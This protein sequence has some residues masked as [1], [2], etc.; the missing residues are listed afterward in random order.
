MMR[1]L[2]SGVSGLKT[3]QQKMDVI[4]NNIANVNTTAFKS[5]ST[6]FQ[7]VMYQT[8]SNASGG[9][10]T[11]GGVN[12]RQIG[13]G[14]TTAANKVS[15]TTQGSSEATGD[16]L[17]LRLVDKQSTNFFIVSDGASN[18]FTRSG[19]FYVDGNGNLAMTST[20]Y[21]VQGWQVDPTTKA[22]KRDTVSPLKVMSA[23]NKTSDP[24]NT[25]KAHI[26]G[27]IDDQ[28]PNVN[29]TSGHVMNLTFYDNLGYSYTARFAVNKGAADTSNPPQTNNYTVALESITSDSQTDSEGNPIDI[30]AN[31]VNEAT[32]ADGQRARLDTIFGSQ[33]GRKTDSFKLDAESYTMSADGQTIRTGS[34][35]NLYTVSLSQITAEAKKGPNATVTFNPTVTGAPAKTVKISDIF[36]G[37]SSAANNYYNSATGAGATATP[38]TMD[39]SFDTKT[40]SLQIQTDAT[41][42]DLKFNATNGSFK[43]ISELNKD[44]KTD[45]SSS[46]STTVLNLRPLGN[47][48]AEEGITIDFSQMLNFDNGGKSTAGVVR[49]T[50]A[51]A[52]DGA[53]KRLGQMTGLSIQ[54]DGQIF[55][56]YSN[57]NTELLGQIPVA[58]FANASGLE[59]LGNNCYQTTLNSGSFD[60]IGEDITS[61]GSSMNS[62]YL[63]M[64]NVDLA[65]E[66]T[67]MITTQRGFQ[68]N[69]RIITVSDTM[70]EELTNLKR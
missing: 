65:Q 63:E 43:S 44:H 22:I 55:A 60:G 2:F 40:Q 35:N 20:G 7:D 25:T 49:G 53:G 26:S 42:V 3:H 64:S 34:G 19:S 17:D 10:N 62:G 6:T 51:D 18:L 57:G 56:S 41:N 67:Q 32:T 31:Y 33:Y 45:D 15:I 52:S 4:G 61:D 23:E 46:G 24:E 8:M 5:T 36:S 70:L 12:A 39:C 29:S 13:L 68:A 14:V 28:D 50:Y 59:S 66:F 69:S 37:L 48:F 27:L 1:S 11:R 9:S 38:V 21:L 58:R 16:G 47:Q 30:L 54:Q